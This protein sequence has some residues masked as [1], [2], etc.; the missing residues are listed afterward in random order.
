MRASQAA[1]APK[2]A[3]KEATSTAAAATS[4]AETEPLAFSD[5]EDAEGEVDDEEEEIPAAVDPP[6]LHKSTLKLKVPSRNTASMADSAGPDSLDDAAATLAGLGDFATESVPAANVS[7][8]K[9]AG[10]DGLSDESELSDVPDEGGSEDGEGSSE[11]GEDQEDDNEGDSSDALGE[12]DDEDEEDEEDAEEDDEEIQN[13]DAPQASTA[14][15][16]RSRHE[17]DRIVLAD[18]EEQA[19]D[20]DAASSLAA[21]AGGATNVDAAPQAEDEEDAEAEDRPGSLPAATQ[22]ANATLK[23]RK[24]SLLGPQILLDPT[25]NDSEPAT[26]R[27]P[28]VEADGA[29][30]GDEDEDEEESDEKAG[31]ADAEGDVDEEMAE[32]PVEAEETTSGAASKGPTSPSGEA[33]AGTLLPDAPELEDEAATDEAA[34][35]RTEAL[36]ALTK[37]ELGFA[38]LRDRLYAERIE[39]VSKEGEMVLDG[40]LADSK[41]VAAEGHHSHYF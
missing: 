40:E 29:E 16:R 31:E 12:D 6:A 1:A 18:P 22:A 3:P 10:T 30:D 38:M 11:E 9:T 21:L 24:H 35:R 25:S 41:A 15:G 23:S 14:R 8:S 36:D 34:L 7:P 27:Q 19:D 2:S 39:E 17:R 13:D 33:A 5:E 37:I 26:S 4:D 32:A 28:S 20:E